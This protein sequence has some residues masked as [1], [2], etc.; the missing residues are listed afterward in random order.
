VCALAE[1]DVE[2]MDG[3]EGGGG[4]GGGGVSVCVGG[5]TLLDVCVYMCVIE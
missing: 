4:G 3:W 2:G 1:K 5:C